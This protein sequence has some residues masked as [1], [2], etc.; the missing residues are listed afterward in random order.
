MRPTAG[1][2]TGTGLTISGTPTPREAEL[3]SDRE[4]TTS[5][6]GRCRLVIVDAGDSV[7]EDAPPGVGLDHPRLAY[8]PL[9]AN[10]AHL[11]FGTATAA[12]YSLLAHV[13]AD[14]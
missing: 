7:W 6:P 4:R 2:R 8:A 13:E 12:A 5:N 14:K 9:I 11:V 10:A 1:H 3:D